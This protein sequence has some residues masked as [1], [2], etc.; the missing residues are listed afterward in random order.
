MVKLTQSTCASGASMKGQFGKANSLRRRRSG[1]KLSSE[2]HSVASCGRVL[3]ME[4][5]MRG[6]WE[7][8]N[9]E[10]AWAG[11]VLADAEKEK[12]EGTQGQWQVESP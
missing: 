7:Y 12:Q 2:K 10:R 11:A 6:M 1:G 8:F 4:Q 5:F 3:G 9:V